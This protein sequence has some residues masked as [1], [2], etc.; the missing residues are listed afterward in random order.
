MPLPVCPV[1]C[2]DSGHWRTV[3]SNPAHDVFTLQAKQ[4]VFKVFAGVPCGAAEPDPTRSREVVG[5]I[6]GL[7]P[8]VEDVALP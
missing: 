5:S 2:D 8:W 4:L 1:G 7:A 3:I 6:P